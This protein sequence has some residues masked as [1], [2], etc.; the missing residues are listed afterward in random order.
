LIGCTGGTRRELKELIDNHDKLQ[1][2]IWK[3]FDLNNVQEA[4]QALFSKERSGR[5]LL[6]VS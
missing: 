5:I 3:R 2:K 4:L 1:V 6:D